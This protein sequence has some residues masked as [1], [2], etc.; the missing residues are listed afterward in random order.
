VSSR[1]RR[2]S[3]GKD[4]TVL[5]DLARSIDGTILHLRCTAV[6]VD[7]GLEYPEVRDFVK[8]I[9]DVSWL[10]PKKSFRDVL[11]Q[12]GYPVVSKETAQ[13]IYEIRHTHSDKLRNRRM[14]GDI[15]GHG[16]I[17]EKWKKLIDA[18][19]KI[20]HMCC[21]VMKKRPIHKY[22]METVYERTG[23]SSFGDSA[24]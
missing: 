24:P 8:S 6:F 10:R 23:C 15:K 22:E 21:T 16:K 1:R 9:K 20:S 12:Y 2:I 13:K 7:T 19:F 18:P 11:S 5:L 17:G 3:G 14:N 4:S